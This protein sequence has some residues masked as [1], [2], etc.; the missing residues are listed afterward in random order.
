MKKKLYSVILTAA[1]AM[2]TLVP[3]ASA[4]GDSVT[5]KTPS[6]IFAGATFTLVINSEY[7][8][9]SY[10]WLSAD[11]ADG[12]F[13]E[14]LTD[15]NSTYIVTPRDKGKYIKARITNN[16]T[17]EVIL[18]DEPVFVEKLGPVSRTSFDTENINNTM[19]TPAENKFGVGGYEFILLDEFDDSD[20][21]YY[22]M[23]E[24]TFGAKPFDTNKYAKFDPDADGNI[25]KFLNGE[26]LTSGNAGK[27]LPEEIQKY[28]NFDHIWYTEGG[29]TKSK[30]AA[31]SAD[32]TED[33]SFTAGISLLSQSEAIKYRSKYGWQ[34]EGQ[35]VVTPW[36]SRTQR[37]SSGM[38][39][40]ILAMMNTSDGGKGN[41]WDK[42]CTT[43]YFIRPTFYLNE[44]FFKEVKLKLDKTG[45]NIKNM[46]VEKYTLSEME[47][48]YPLEDLI[49]LGYDI[50]STVISKESVPYSGGATVLIASMNDNNAVEFDYKW[51]LSDSEE[52]PGKQVYANTTDRYIIGVNDRNKYISVA[53]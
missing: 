50:K 8:D 3:F 26:F 6:K 31:N 52:E 48:L 27:I 23:T 18:S 4:E 42:V 16:E 30:D 17:G 1:M 47:A 2:G 20:S 22:V 24:T 21:C 25:A 40:N 32:C 19:L 5:I 15:T 29:L 33:Y 41:M 13:K 14:I 11:S 44:N 51:Y 37:G 12:E 34:A 49:A 35:S 28:I 46:L 39:D 7:E 43:N 45:T 38:D 53:L 36:W 9:F 10:Q